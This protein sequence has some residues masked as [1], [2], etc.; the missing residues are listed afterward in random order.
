MA[1]TALERE[2]ELLARDPGSLTREEMTELRELQERGY[3]IIRYYMQGRNVTLR[4]G[5]T[6]AEARTHCS[7]PETSSS[8]CTSAA[9]KRRTRQRGPWFD[10]YDR[11]R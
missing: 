3:R 2:A 11:E 10:G 7:D 6:L 4:T 8:T 1:Q 9:G 5:C